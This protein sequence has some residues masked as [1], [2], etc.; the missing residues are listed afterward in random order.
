MFVR[1]TNH[2][3]ARLLVDSK[4]ASTKM[5]ERPQRPF[6]LLVP[7]FTPKTRNNAAAIPPH[8]TIAHV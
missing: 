2:P 7:N 3:A 1:I 5:E 8:E 6:F 4:Y